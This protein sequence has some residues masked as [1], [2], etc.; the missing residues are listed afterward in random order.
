MDL[1]PKGSGDLAVSGIT[2][3]ILL[4]AMRMS[5]LVVGFCAPQ[6]VILPILDGFRRQDV[7]QLATV[8]VRVRPHSDGLEHLPLNLNTLVSD[9]RVME[10]SKDVIDNL[11][12]GDTRVLPCI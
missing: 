8:W 3:D 6:D 2:G 10:D 5:A 12:N 7:I 9:R 11:V 4:S 1:R